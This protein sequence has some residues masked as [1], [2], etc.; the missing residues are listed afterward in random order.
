MLDSGAAAA[1]RAFM[2]ISQIDKLTPQRLEQELETLVEVGKALTTQLTLKEV[3]QVVMSKVSSLLN[4][5]AWSLL[6]LDD[7]TGELCFEIAVSPVAQQLKGVRL[8]A[9]EGIAGYVVEQGEPLLVPDVS[10]NEHYSE[11]IGEQTGFVTQS[12]VCVPL[13]IHDK[14]LGVIQLLNSMEQGEFKGS[15]LRILSTIA[16]FAAIAMENAR[17]VD[18]VREL[19]IT[20]DLTGLYNSRHFQKLIDYEVE[21]ARRQGTEVSLV[22]LD[23]D[24]FK[25][26]NDTYGHLTGSRLLSEVGRTIAANTRKVDHAARYGGDEF[27]ILLPGAGNDNALG[28]VNSLRKLFRETD[29]RSD[30]GQPINVTSSVGIATYPTNAKNRRELI[31][32]ADEAMYAVKKSTRDGVLTA[33]DLPPDIAAPKS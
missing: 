1:C 2:D 19:T 8:P 17:L 16:D 24:H 3:Y 28:M 27:V 25:Q 30:C 33:Y 23:L 20:D 26:V 5:S 31:R 22:F 7:A 11:K 29:F 21:R 32:L 15:D 18:K 4:P 9:G 12:I 10:K 6:I 14:V 13:K